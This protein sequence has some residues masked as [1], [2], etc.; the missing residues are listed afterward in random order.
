MLLY[1]Q[2]GQVKYCSLCRQEKVNILLYLQRGQVKILLYL[3]RG[4]GQHTALLDGKRSSYCV[5]CR[6]E[7]QACRIFQTDKN[8]NILYLLTKTRAVTCRKR[9]KLFLI[10]SKQVIN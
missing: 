8:T 3:Q 2:T 6:Q 9:G 5:I 10:I 1:L 7:W 4:K